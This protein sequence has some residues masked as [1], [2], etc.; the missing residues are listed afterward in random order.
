MAVALILLAASDVTGTTLEQHVTGTTLEQHVRS[1]RETAKDIRAATET[2]RDTAVSALYLSRKTHNVCVETY[3]YIIFALLIVTCYVLHECR[4]CP[5]Q[6]KAINSQIAADSIENMTRGY[7]VSH[8]AGV[9][10][11]NEVRT[12]AVQYHIKQSAP[13]DI[14]F[15]YLEFYVRG[16]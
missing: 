3:S 9:S 13:Q 2:L 5:F 4:L 12:Q 10:L 16:I 14:C 7:M 8:T 1:I 6:R 15:K 11:N